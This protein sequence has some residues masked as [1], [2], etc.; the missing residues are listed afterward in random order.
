MNAIAM[1]ANHGSTTNYRFISGL[2]EMSARCHTK[3]P[4]NNKTQEKKKERMSTTATLRRLSLLDNM[5]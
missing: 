1:A 5:K 4:L 3:F 2:V